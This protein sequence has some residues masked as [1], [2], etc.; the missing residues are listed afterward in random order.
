MKTLST[1][2]ALT[3][4][5]GL[6]ACQ[7]ATEG[8]ETTDADAATAGDAATPASSDGE[9]IEARVREGLWQI[10]M[11][12]DGAQGLST[13]V[14]MD[15][16]MSAIDSA[17]NSTDAV[18]EDCDQTTTRTAD[19]FDFS[20][21]CALADGS[22]TETQGTMTGD[23]QTNYR[24]QA[25]VTTTGSTVAAANG[26]HEIVTQGAYQ[27]A[28]PEGWRPG[29]MELPGGMGRVNVLDAQAQITAPS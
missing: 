16:R 1:L 4:M 7:P 3:A 21:R 8:A 26:T 14:C 24:M 28:C 25:T 10:T 19:G 9:V 23:M 13:R 12:A 18:G 15:E 2:C 17:Q 22:V 29:D 5:V 20:S 6:A 11:S 27:G